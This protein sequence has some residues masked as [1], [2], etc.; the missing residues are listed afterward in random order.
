MVKKN[1]YRILVTF[2]AFI[3]ISLGI[4]IGFSTTSNGSKNNPNFTLVKGSDNDDDKE[5]EDINYSE[6][7][8]EYTSVSTKT[9]DIELIYR[10]H[11]TLCNHT[12]E[13]KRVEY[14]V[15]LDELK[16]SEVEKQQVNNN[17]YNIVEE[18]NERLIFS[19]N[20][21]QNCPNHFLVKL[22][23]GSVVIYNV[24]K[25]GVN[26]V[27]KKLDISQDSIMPELLEE[28]N[29]V[30]TVDSK[31]QLNFIIEDIES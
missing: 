19:R 3:L 31:E 24:V 25:E 18:S 16:K 15:T 6:Q 28:L 22:E 20:I 10:D 12:I 30:I 21:N 14:G 17:E 7:T 8:D 27:Y 4:Y 9:Y 26:T 23:N 1:E 2:I 13:D 11:Y 29:S 5:D